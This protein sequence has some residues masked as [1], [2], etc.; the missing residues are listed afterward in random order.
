MYVCLFVCMYVCFVLLVSSAKAIWVEWQRQCQ[1][2]FL[3]RLHVGCTRDVSWHSRL[4]SLYPF[5][6]GYFG[7]R[8][9]API[10]WTMTSVLF[11]VW[12]TSVYAFANRNRRKSFGDTLRQSVV[13]FLLNAETETATV[14]RSLRVHCERIGRSF[15]FLFFFF[16]LLFSWKANSAEVLLNFSIIK[17]TFSIKPDAIC[18]R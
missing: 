13:F 5:V 9:V 10:P 2:M 17:P 12:L 18:R 6:W 4:G 8:A 3:H 16:V 15:S 7:L 1:E 14:L 11:S